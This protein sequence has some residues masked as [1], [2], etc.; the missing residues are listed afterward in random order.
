MQVCYPSKGGCFSLG[1]KA[2]SNGN[3]TE[4]ASGKGH[5]KFIFSV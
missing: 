2:A 5:E 4:F 1:M 3:E